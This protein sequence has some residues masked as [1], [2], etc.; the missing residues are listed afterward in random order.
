[1]V[2]QRVGYN[3]NLF[4]LSKMF[5]GDTNS[6]RSETLFP[7]VMPTQTS[8]GS[9][10]SVNGCTFLTSVTS[11]SSSGERDAR[12]LDYHP[13]VAAWITRCLGLS[14]SKT[15]SHL[16]L[17]SGRQRGSQRYRSPAISHRVVKQT[18]A[19]ATMQVDADIA[20]SICSALSCIHWLP[21]H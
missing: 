14:S 11:D 17:G 20:L 18:A 6:E 3:Y 16:H 19:V 13:V 8:K 1:M 7:Y 2:N 9:D 12:P 21:P 10:G 5:S 4:P 15:F